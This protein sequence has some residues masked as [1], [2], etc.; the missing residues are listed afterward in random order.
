MT[1]CADNST[2]VSSAASSAEAAIVTTA[3]P[4]TSK[5]ETTTSVFEEPLGGLTNPY[6]LY[7]QSDGTYIPYDCSFICDCDFDPDKEYKAGDTLKITASVTNLT[8]EDLYF[9][10]HIG[11][12]NV[13]ELGENFCFVD[14]PTNF[15]GSGE[16]LS[17]S[18][19]YTFEKEGVFIVTVFRNFGV[20]NNIDDNNPE[21]I[22][23]WHRPACMYKIIVKE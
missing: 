7:L 4:Q 17:D 16:T 6:D 8:N 5:S 15:C 22:Y 1:S 19:E 18:R 12:I 13:A 23:Y 20:F 11:L 9:C 10:G 3:A 14:G 2:D 21:I